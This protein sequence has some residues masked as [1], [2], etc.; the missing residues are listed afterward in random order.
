MQGI[1]TNLT[2]VTNATD[3]VGLAMTALIQK[4]INLPTY[5]GWQPLGD[6]PQLM[7]GNCAIFVEPAPGQTPDLVS[8]GKYKRTFDFFI[9]W[10]VVD[11]SAQD[12][13]SLYTSIGEN[14]IKL[15]SLNALN[16][17][18]TANPPSNNFRCYEPYWDDSDMGKMAGVPTFLNVLEGRSEKYMRRGR[19]TIN[20][21]QELVKI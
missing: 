19:L 5:Y 9:Y 10:Y 12:I 8:L 3:I 1:A 4:Y 6:N 16:D 15:F 14:L 18:E 21:R 2:G 11:N 17:K 20:V 13:V 7:K